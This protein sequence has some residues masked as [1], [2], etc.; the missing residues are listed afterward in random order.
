MNYES[1]IR[2]C[3]RSGSSEKQKFC[4]LHRQVCI[5]MEPEEYESIW[6]DAKKVRELID[7]TMKESPELF[8]QKMREQGYRLTGH[9]PESKKMPGIKLRQIRVGKVRY[10]LRPSFVMGY[11]SGTVDKLDNPLFLLSLGVPT[12]AITRVFGRNDMYWY[13]Q[14]ERLGRNSLVGTT[15]NLGQNLPLHIAA[16]EHHARWCKEKGYVAMTVGNECILGMGLSQSADE[17]NLTTAYS[18]FAEEAKLLDRS[19]SAVTVNTDGWT[20]TQNAFLALFPSITLILCFL[21]GF[22]KIRDRCRKAYELHNR[23]WEVYHAST[24]RE[25]K[26]GL[27][28]LLEWMKKKTWPVVVQQAVDKLVTRAAEYQKSYSHPQCLRTSNMVDRLMNRLTRY[29]YAGR[30]LHGHQKT[31]ELRLRGWALL[32]N[33]TPYAPRSNHMRQY[34]SPAHRINQKKYHEHWLH[35]L[36]ISASMAGFRPGVT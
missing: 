17:K 35:N 27:E 12:W 20:A 31:S 11:M 1:K 16:D 14:V 29:L 32:N 3:N 33:F 2:S 25:F 21:H 36:N 19:Y 6:S 22:L 5:Y 23:I 9:L 13:Q 26:K 4:R 8:P 15:I 7:Q 34:V 18:D 24:A 30:G 28:Q 10:S